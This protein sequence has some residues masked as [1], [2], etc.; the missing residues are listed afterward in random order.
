MASATLDPYRPDLHSWLGNCPASKCYDSVVNATSDEFCGA[1]TTNLC[2]TA[3]YDQDHTLTY[4]LDAEYFVARVAVYNVRDAELPL[5]I[6]LAK[7]QVAFSLQIA[8]NIVAPPTLTG[9]LVKLDK[10]PAMA[11]L[12]KKHNLRPF[13]LDVYRVE[14]NYDAFG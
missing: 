9:E 3:Y 4:T 10:G 6:M 2:H 11:H 14:F 5:R 8:A 7:D 1:A 13:I 12:Q